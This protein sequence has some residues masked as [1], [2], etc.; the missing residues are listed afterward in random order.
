VGFVVAGDEG[1]TAMHFDIAAFLKSLETSAVASHIRD[2]LLL[3]PLLESTH[4]FAVALVFGTI[5]VIDLRLLG[6]ASASRSFQHMASD[7]LRWTWAAFALTAATGGLMFLTNATVYY[8][9]FYFRAK[10]VLLLLAALNMFVFEMTAG[11]KTDHW[12]T[13]PSAPRP[14]K[15]VAVLSIVI[16]IGVI[17]VGR[18]IG[19]TTTRAAVA[20]PPP[21]S[22]DFNDFLGGPSTPPPSSGK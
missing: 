22:V 10:M 14:G 16:W 2:S 8:H 12:H 11:R 9:N 6:L 13:A 5:G 17:F 21:S 3:F 19:F 20:A 7:I 4:V 15:T 1:L 18:M